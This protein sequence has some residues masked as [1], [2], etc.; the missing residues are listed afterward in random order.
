MMI[1]VDNYNDIRTL[2]KLSHYPT[3]MD[4]FDFEA[5]RDLSLYIVNN[6]LETSIPIPTSE[7]VR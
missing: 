6:A 5:R 1:P 3:L 4:Y 7:E 2:L